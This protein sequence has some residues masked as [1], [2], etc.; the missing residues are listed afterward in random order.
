[1]SEGYFAIAITRTCGSG[2]GSYI[3]RKLAADYRI[4]F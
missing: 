4:D 2:G 3:G 1:M